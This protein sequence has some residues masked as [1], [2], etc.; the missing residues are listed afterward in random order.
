MGFNTNR[1]AAPTT[2]AARDPVVYDPTIKTGGKRMPTLAILC[3][4]PGSGKST[5]GRK[6]KADRGFFVVSTDALR[7]AVNAGVYP[8]QTGGEYGTLEPV[9]WELARLAVER[10]LGAGHDAAIDAIAGT[11]ERRAEW[12]ELARRVVPDARVEL[13]WCRGT[14]DSAERWAKERDISPDEYREIRSRLEREF[15][16]PSEAEADELVVHSAP[17]N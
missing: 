10:L 15:I 11:P 12:W 17:T 9:V 7:L 14:W 8:K 16:P 5:L 13:H 4:L 2:L 3:G 1:F 6:L